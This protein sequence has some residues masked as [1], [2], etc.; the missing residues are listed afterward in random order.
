MASSPIGQR[1]GAMLEEHLVV[2]GAMIH[3]KRSCM[4]P[5]MHA[6]FPSNE[7]GSLYL[8][9]DRIVVVVGRIGRRKL[10]AR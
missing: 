8:S 10:F 2:A 7:I 3:L 5:D 6:G 9:L 1:P 4:A